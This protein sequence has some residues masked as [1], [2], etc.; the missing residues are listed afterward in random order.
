MPMKLFALA[1]L[2]LSFAKPKP[3]DI[4]G[5]AWEDHVDRLRENWLK[6]VDRDDLVLLCGDLSWAMDLA[7]AR[8]DLEF[9]QNLPGRKVIIRGNHDYWWKSKKKLTEAF[10]GLTFLHADAVSID[11][12]LICGTRFWDHPAVSWGAAQNVLDG[13]KPLTGSQLESDD[14]SRDEQDQKIRRRELIRLD[15]A[16]QAAGKLRKKK[17]HKLVCLLHYPPVGLRPLSNSLSVLLAEAGVDVCVFG[18]V[19][20]IDRKRLTSF[21]QVIDGVRF[22]CV[23]GDLVNFTPVR[24][25]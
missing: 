11:E 20:N 8:P 16:L 7:G 22:V 19:H 13:N 25:Y 23:S 10:G 15:L 14:Q 5:P 24:I 6:T 18:H 12:L 21:D 4:F 3:M 9:I 17:E 1:D 2:H